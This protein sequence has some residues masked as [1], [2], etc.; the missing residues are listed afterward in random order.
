M[1]ACWWECT[2]AITRPMGYCA[3]PLAP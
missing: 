1:P 3:I 2:P